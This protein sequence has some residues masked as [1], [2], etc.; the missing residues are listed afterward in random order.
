VLTQNHEIDKSSSA[1]KRGDIFF[2]QSGEIDKRCAAV[3]G[4]HILFTSDGKLDYQAMGISER[5]NPKDVSTSA[6]RD[7]SSQVRHRKESRSKYL[8]EK[9]ACHIVDLSVCK[10]FLSSKPGRHSTEEQLHENLK[11]LNELL[12]MRS[13]E[14]N[15]KLDVDMAKRIEDLYDGKNVRVTRGMEN[16]INFMCDAIDSIPEEKMNG[17]LKWIQTQLHFLKSKYC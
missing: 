4:G 12:R 9:E 6:Y 8:K 1:C 7:P 15:R 14:T 3:C 11:P 13:K 10:K 2:T 16:R 17:D 5:K